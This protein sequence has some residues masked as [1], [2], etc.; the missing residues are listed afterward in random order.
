MLL[1]LGGLT[2]A[3]AWLWP[4]TGYCAIFGWLSVLLIV[5]GLKHSQ[6]P[7]RHAYFAALILNTIGFYWLNHAISSFGGFGYASTLAIFSL[8]V[9]LSSV[10][11]L[12]AVFIWR[13]LPKTFHNLAIASPV[14]FVAS[15]VI[16]IRLFPWHFG[17]TQ[18]AV[19]P[20]AQ[21]ADLGGT[22][23]LSFLMFWVIETILLI[24]SQRKICRVAIAPL[25]SLLLAMAYGHFRMQQFAKIEAPSQRVALIQANISIDEK[26]DIKL[27]IPNVKRY[28]E[29]SAEVAQEQTLIIWPESVI[30]SWIFAKI[31]SV[32]FDPRLPFIGDNIPM[33]IGA[34][35][36]DTDKSRYNS[37]LA[38]LADGTV[39]YPYHK[40]I[41][42]PFGEFVP[43]ANIFPWLRDLAAGIE[44]FSAGK[45]VSVFNYPLLSLEGEKHILKVA[46][47]ICYEDV[48]PGLAR[49][50][51]KNGATLLVNLT[52]DGWFG[53]S[54]ALKQHHL[55][56]SFRAI[57]NRRYL[58]RATNTGLTAVVNPLGKTTQQLRPFSDGTLVS[59]IKSISYLSPQTI[60]N[61]NTLWQILSWLALILAGFRCWRTKASTLP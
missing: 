42:M 40:Q 32:K 52:N 16:T 4:G 23:L 10:Q 53:N 43:F 57:E 22:L 38:I 17:H 21:I 24:Q 20:I 59:D 37:A 30:L 15:E 7:Y 31:E 61:P 14:A 55:I 27:L 12:V 5:G 18:L 34:L 29:L 46:P 6:T 35:T 28:L 54:A 25:L 49:E 60:Y 1:P 41:L 45:E 33:L 56:A 48:V 47:L 9:I 50:A 11:F 58:L 19:T 26:H 2:I 51:V 13:N 36:Y 44:D 39:P 3:I 8:F